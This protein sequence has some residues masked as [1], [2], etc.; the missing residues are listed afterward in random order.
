MFD[1]Y[2]SIQTH[3]TPFAAHEPSDLFRKFKQLFACLERTF[4][5]ASIF[6]QVK[7]VGNHSKNCQ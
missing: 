3:P 5:D 1:G 7:N 2:C 4:Y 6:T